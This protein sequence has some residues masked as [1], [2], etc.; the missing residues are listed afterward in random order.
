M[1][2]LGSSVAVVGCPIDV[3]A[4]T[5]PAVIQQILH[6][7]TERTV[8]DIAQEFGQIGIVD[9]DVV[10]LDQA[11]FVGEVT[12]TAGKTTVKVVLEAIAAISAAI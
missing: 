9:I 4:V 6:L 2:F 11:G 10:V 8:A 12:G 1:K 3:A 5:P 7:H